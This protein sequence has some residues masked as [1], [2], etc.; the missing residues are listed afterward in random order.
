MTE[1]KELTLAPQDSHSIMRLV[2]SAMGRPDFDVA[3]LQELL[4]LKER[5]D[6]NEAR[7]AFVVA[8]N[9]FKADPPELEKTKTVK[10]GATSFKH[11][12]LDKVCEVVG[13]ALAKHQISHRW[14][15]EQSEKIIKVT[16][17][18]THELGHSE[19]VT[20]QAEA[21]TSG[22]KNAI[23]AIGSAV[24][25]LQRYTLFAATGLAAK[26]QDDDGKGAN[27]NG[28]V[29][30]QDQADELAALIKETKSDTTK[31]LAFVGA[32]SLPDITPD[33]YKK[34]LRMLQK[35]RDEK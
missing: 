30:T 3:K 19:R 29:I 34:G 24:T 22:S 23:Q 18:L 15:V 16:C 10:F 27:G 12:T 2:E 4:A 6:A 20:M 35:K 26:D 28:G 7:K 21:D 17:V 9:A 14:T 25:Y 5:W 8:L 31:F 11:A 33:G 1:T 32:A 13:A